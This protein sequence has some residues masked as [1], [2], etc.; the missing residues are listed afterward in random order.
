MVLSVNLYPP[1]PQHLQSSGPVKYKLLSSLK[2]LQQ[3]AEVISELL[4]IAAESSVN[5]QLDQSE[6]HPQPQPHPFLHY[7]THSSFFITLSIYLFPLCN[8][9]FYLCNSQQPIYSHV[10]LPCKIF[11]ICT[12]VPFHLSIIFLIFQFCLS[13]QPMTS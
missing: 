5:P 10:F 3:E 9:T 1:H 7:L 6:S 13:L 8:S 11:L 12:L 4:N 2:K